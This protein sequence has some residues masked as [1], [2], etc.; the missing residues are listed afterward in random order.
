MNQMNQYISRAVDP[1]A[2][3][4][5]LAMSEPSDIHSQTFLRFIIRLSERLNFDIPRED[6]PKLATREGAVRYVNELCC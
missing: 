4:Q 5:E 3:R 6:Y 1:V 2:L